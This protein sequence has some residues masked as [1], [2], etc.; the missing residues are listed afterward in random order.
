MRSLKNLKFSIPIGWKEIEVDNYKYFSY[1]GGD[2]SIVNNNYF[3]INTFDRK[4][5]DDISKDTLSVLEKYCDYYKYVTK[6]QNNV[7]SVIDNE[8]ELNSGSKL[9]MLRFLIDNNEKVESISLIRELN[10][11]IIECTIKVDE[12]KREQA[13]L[14]LFSILR[15]L[16]FCGD[17]CFSPFDNVRFIDGQL[18]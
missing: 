3:I 16:Q 8:I 15:G 7:V 6:N 10:N 9:R 14:C 13:I 18:L 1:F 5:I 4:I 17:R 12:S 11:N 2:D